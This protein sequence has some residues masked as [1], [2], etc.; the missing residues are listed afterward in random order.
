MVTAIYRFG[1]IELNPA[2]RQLLVDK[3]PALLGARALDVLLALIERRDRLVTKNELLA[4]VWPRLV[5]EENNLQ[6]QISRLR[7]AY[8]FL[9]GEMASRCLASTTFSGALTHPI[10][11]RMK[12]LPHQICYPSDWPTGV[13]HGE[14]NQHGNTQGTGRGG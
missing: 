2:T 7:V 10:C 6:V 3:Q 12:L 8:C 4:L 9:R 14:A 11:Y 1:R 13:E 5:V